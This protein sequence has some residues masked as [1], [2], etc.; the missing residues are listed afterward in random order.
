MAEFTLVLLGA[1]EARR[2]RGA[3]LTLPKKTRALLAYLALTPGH[4][5]PRGE[6]ATLL[7]GDTGDAQARQSLRQA[8]RRLRETLGPRSGAIRAD[9]DMVA[10]H[11]N[12]LEID[13]VTFERLIAAGGPEAIGRAVALYRGELLAGLDVDEKPFEDWLVRQ[14]ERLREMALAAVGQL[15]ACHTEAGA[16]DEAVRAAVRLLTLDPLHE[17]THRALM[18]IYAA[19]GRRSAA[20]RQYQACVEV[21]QRELGVE[22][23][24]ETKE[25]YQDLVRERAATAFA[26]PAPRREPLHV[27]R[28]ETVGAQKP[29]AF[30]GREAERGRLEDLLNEAVRG[31]GRLAAILGEAGIG[32]TRLVSWMAET[33]AAAGARVLVGRSYASE[34]I[35][36]FGPWS[37]AL[38]SGLA[39]D[40]DL[41]SDLDERWRSEVAHLVP[42]LWARGVTPPPSGDDPVRLFESVVQLVTHL[43]ET[44][45]LLVVLEDL[46]WADEISL[47]LVAV[48][49]R[50][51]RTRPLLIV[52]TAR[53]EELADNVALRDLL[54]DLGRDGRLFSMALTPLSQAEIGALVRA[55]AHLG[56][57]GAV[58]QLVAQVWATSEG[59]PFMAVE[60]VRALE[61]GT[62]ASASSDLAVPERIREVVSGRLERV[63]ERGRLLL[64]IAAVIGR[65]FEFGLLERSAAL[66]E[67]EAAVGVEEL[68]RRRLFRVVDE[69]FEFTH[70]RIR[71]VTYG[72]LLPPRRRL[73]HRQVAEV[74]ET[75]HAD[76]LEPHLAT[77]GRH[78]YEAGEWQKAASYLRRAG[79]S[80]A[81]R[82][83]SREAVASFR[84]A[85][86]A[87]GRVP[88]TPETLAEAIDICLA[89]RNPLVL[90]EHIDRL[91]DLHTEAQRLAERL[92]DPARLARVSVLR[93]QYL[94]WAGRPTEALRLASDAQSIGERLGDRSVAAAAT[95]YVFSVLLTSGDYRGVEAVGETFKRQYEA[96]DFGRRGHGPTMF[97]WVSYVWTRAYASAQRGA[98]D[99][100]FAILHEGRTVAEEADHRHVLIGVYWMFGEVHIVRG[101]VGEAVG[102][103]ERALGLCWE[104]GVPLASPACMAALGY[105]YVLDGRIQDGVSRLRDALAAMESMGW[106]FFRSLALVRLGEACVIAGRLPEALE[107]AQRALTLAREREERGFEAWALRLLADV[108][109]RG[110]PPDI[111]A[112]ADLFKQAMGRA[113]E[114]DMQPLIGHAHL[115]LG[116]MYGRCDKRDQARAHLTAA[117]TLF[118]ERGMPGWRERAETEARALATPATTPRASHR[119]RRPT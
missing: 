117:A 50:R 61:Q 9:D 112:A 53:E 106:T 16:V 36:P 83:A 75:L 87:I 11:L 66:G 34:Q 25:L 119:A 15:L 26:R 103:L 4:A 70:D 82:G 1:F 73:L 40:P 62:A 47:R 38:R 12:A 101:A 29:A 27:V 24:A 2:P 46:H 5:C 49:S 48:V 21:L 60:T 14:R 39:D 54:R 98:F 78:L 77:L 32:K 67:I 33:A 58:A 28:S 41:F 84:H 79:R 63:S 45:P 110:A 97:P 107:V 69:R 10:L 95:A 22:P 65:D 105:A 109:A 99:R 19:Q 23:E 3:A 85:L 108:A 111:G 88:E 76:Q 118:A 80:A 52:A 100:A 64:A 6:L 30:V 37:D 92:G 96:S 90:T 86:D 57:A 94:W 35:L 81:E 89:L 13:T 71:E 18:R 55:V 114:L 72:Q 91:S 102:A 68:V 116:S 17:P 74:I 104:W 51:L 7:W 115:G 8:L 113:T 43:A 42:E 56:D 44:R 59:H 93:S 20:L 31:R